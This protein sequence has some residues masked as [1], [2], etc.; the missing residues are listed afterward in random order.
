[1]RVRTAWTATYLKSREVLFKIRAE[2]AREEA[3]KS[4]PVLLRPG[5]LASRPRSQLL[6]NHNRLFL[7]PWGSDL[8]IPKKQR[9]ERFE[10]ATLFLTRTSTS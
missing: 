5:L 6:V 10:G 2:G 1:M 3:I 8:T 7:P 9:R 4:V